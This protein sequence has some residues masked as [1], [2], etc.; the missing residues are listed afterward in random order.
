MNDNLI[1]IYIFILIILVLLIYITLAKLLIRVP[2]KPVLIPK[3]S[4]I[5]TLIVSWSL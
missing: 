5:N 4:L 2:W 1:S 3:I